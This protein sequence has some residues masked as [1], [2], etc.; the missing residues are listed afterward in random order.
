MIELE[1]DVMRLVLTVALVQSSLSPPPPCTYCL[2]HSFFLPGIPSFMPAVTQKGRAALSATT[3][4]KSAHINSIAT[5]MH[6]HTV[7]PKA[8]AN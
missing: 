5:V 4:F 3:A 7:H 6:K 2:L 8:F 1:F